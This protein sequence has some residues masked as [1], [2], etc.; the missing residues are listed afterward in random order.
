L[1]ILY[2]YFFQIVFCNDDSP[3]IRKADCSCPIGLSEACGHITGL[4]YQLA[5]NKVLSLKSL[6][7]DVAKTSQAQ[8]W[9]TRRGKKIKS[10]EVQDLEV[11][12]YRK[13]DLDRESAPRTVKSTLYN[14]VR[15]GQVDW[16]GHHSNLSEACPNMLIL[17]ALK[18]YDVP[19]INTKFGKY[20]K[21]SVLSYHQ[22]LESN[23]IIN[24]YDG[25]AFPDLPLE[26]VMQ[27]EYS[28][29]ITESQLVKRITVGQGNH[30]WS[31]L[32]V[33]YY[34]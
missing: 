11:A 30:S 7:E 9:H 1:F 21:G 23:C 22:P 24:I 34:N 12:G 15:R 5:K 2:N 13:V 25:I 16:C 19:I 32:K 18:N 17:P 26:N 6:P 27:K 3:T 8:T 4:L 10:K 29:V 33:I 14:P 20:P 31:S 28:F